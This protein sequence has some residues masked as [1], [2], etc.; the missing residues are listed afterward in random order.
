MQIQAK[1]AIKVIAI[2]M[3]RQTMRMLEMVFHGPGREDYELVEQFSA[4]QAC[5]V[6]LD[7]IEGNQLWKDNRHQYAQ[8]PT[9]ILSI[10]DK[11]ITGTFYLKK[12][13]E[14]EKLLKVLAKVK[15]RVEE[16]IRNQSE[17]KI[18][19]TKKSLQ[20]VPHDAKLSSEIA[21]EEEEE[22][23]HDFCGHHADINPHNPAEVNKIYY[24]PSQYLQGFLTKAFVLGEQ[25]ETGGIL[26]DG[27][28]IP[29]ILLPKNNQILCNYKFQDSQLRT[30]T[31]LPL[32]NSHLQ[33]QKLS[34][35]ELDDYL[36]R[37]QLMGQ[38]LDNF[39]WRVALWTARGRV[40][41]GTDFHK[42]IVLLHWP[43]FSRLV[44]TPHAL[45]ISALWIAQPCSLLETAYLLQIPQRYVFAFYSAAHAL[46]LA[47]E[48]RRIEQ[49][50]SGS[51]KLPPANTKR[52]LFQHLLAR[53]LTITG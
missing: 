1:K 10:H 44:V 11:E 23:I 52:N 42:K 28:H 22:S 16:Q 20:T 18:S 8:L 14:I 24:T 36:T 50:R 49:Q 33:I 34:G 47:Y 41:K 26:L 27:L 5:I 7:S 39:I 38:P 17:A 3:Q 12:P 9:I 51:R 2:G 29:M 19:L 25:L 48:E 46:Q 21:M 30:M 43:N 37:Q 31:L 4:A 32:S 53:L 40:P 6:D 35:S 15:Q 45:K 13:M